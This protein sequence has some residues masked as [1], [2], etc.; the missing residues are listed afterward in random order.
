MDENCGHAPSPQS[1]IQSE[2]KVEVVYENM[3]NDISRLDTTEADKAKPQEKQEL[4]KP[5][6]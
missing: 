6:R 5:Q 2:P 3:L 1:E 4:E